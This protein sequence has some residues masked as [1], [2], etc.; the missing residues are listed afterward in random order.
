MWRMRN[1][2]RVPS[3]RAQ[4]LRDELFPKREGLN[5]VDAGHVIGVDSSTVRRYIRDGK[6]P[7]IRIGRDF[8]IT[9][10]DLRA[11]VQG[12]QARDKEDRLEAARVTRIQREIDRFI[13][14]ARQAGQASD[15]ALA[16][17]SACGYRSPVTL[18]VDI[19]DGVVYGVEWRGSCRFCPDQPSL[20]VGDYNYYRSIA[21]EDEEASRKAI[22]LGFDDL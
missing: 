11:F 7:A 13:G 22:D 1:E 21:S 3:V 19:D 14:R 8:S 6:L 4:E 2:R 20:G 12:K 18:N 9:E 15:V 5:T 10:E 17:C 16:W